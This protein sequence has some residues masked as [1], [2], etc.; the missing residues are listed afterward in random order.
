[1]ITM[2]IEL[3]KM[4]FALLLGAI[5]LPA[6]AQTPAPTSAAAPALVPVPAPGPT[7]PYAQSPALA[8]AV[9]EGGAV[10]S[11]LQA[12]ARLA[13]AELKRMMVDRR[14]AEREQICYTK[15]FVNNC[16]GR[17]KDEQREALAGVRE[18]EIDASYFKR[19]DA[20]AKR[21]QAL[22]DS[23]VITDAQP[24]PVRTD[25][26]EAGAMAP[27][28]A[29]DSARRAASHQANIQRQQQ[30]D[31]AAA[32]R[33]AGNTAAYEK[34]QREAEERQRKRTAKDAAEAIKALGGSNKP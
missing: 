32:A 25:K 6:L 26:V 18:I 1:M 13:A 16:L 24:R 3:K 19:L 12:D 30:R 7:Q 27:P 21:D 33:S 4:T 34:K 23:N 8:A 29:D 14:F 17:A 20:V 10:T 5:V 11:V 9:P 31:D 22:A 15:F 28:K 2:V